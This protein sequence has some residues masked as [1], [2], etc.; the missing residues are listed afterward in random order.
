[1]LASLLLVAALAAAPP[2]PG[3]LVVT[4][5]MV[6]PDKVPD[7]Y[8][9]WFEVLNT[10]AEDLDL[11]GLEVSDGTWREAFAVVPPLVIGAGDYLV[12]G[13]SA[14]TDED[15]VSFNG[16]IPVDYVYQY[17]DFHL[18]PDVG[19]IQLVLDGVTLDW[20]R[21]Y[22]GDWQVQ[23]Q[24]SHQVSRNAESLEWANDLHYNWCS[25]EHYLDPLG[26][27]ATPGWQNDWCA[28]QNVDSD[29]DGYKPTDGDC[30]DRDPYV[31]PGAIDGSDGVLYGNPDDDAD[32]DGVRDDGDTDDDGDG[33]SEVGGDCDDDDP[34][35]FPGADEA[36]YDGID[37]N[38]D[39]ASDFDADG[40]GHDAEPWGADCDDADPAIHPGAFDVPG[41]TVDQ[42]C[43]GEAAPRVGPD[44]EADTGDTASDG[45]TGEQDTGESDTGGQEERRP[46]PRPQEGA[47]GGCGSS[48]GYLRPLGLL[49]LL[50]A[51]RR[52]VSVSLAR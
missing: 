51:P 14:D 2:R 15:S 24:L 16:N 5:F 4:E 49:A 36:W 27:K 38:C 39:G 19:V 23:K 18:S 32:C 40:D 35:V 45:D 1:M 52:R 47:C 9:Q 41:D 43:D 8:G 29:G 46:A 21:W 11:Q 37:Q 13:V 20:V 6:Q 22:P 50:L 10:T 3:D 25:S 33:F 7:Y 26:L 28:G 30:D 48:G 42:D 17:A 34:G 31:N 44:V 12:F